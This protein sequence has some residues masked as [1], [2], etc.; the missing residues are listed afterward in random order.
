MARTE[1]KINFGRVV[2]YGNPN[3]KYD[4][5]TEEW[6]KQDDDRNTVCEVLDITSI[7]QDRIVTSKYVLPLSD[8]AISNSEEGLVYSFNCS[9]PY[10]TETAHLAEVE[11]NIIVQQAFLYAGRTQPVKTN[12]M[13]VMIICFMGLLAV[14]GMF[15]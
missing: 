10:L 5:E 4:R 11:Q 12:M 3:Y 13:M 1:E 7:G 8:A 9:L 15:K 14:I 2:I 6:S